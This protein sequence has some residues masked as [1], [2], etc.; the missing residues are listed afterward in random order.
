MAG[1]LALLV[2]GAATAGGTLN[3]SSAA[4]PNS[5]DPHIATGGT[6]SY[7]LYDLFMGLTSFDADGRVIPGAAE[8]WSV[9]ADGLAYT[10]T[11]RPGLQW[12]DG[13]TLTSEDFLYSAR[14]VVTPATA[15]RFAS[16]FYPVKNARH[17]LRGELPPDALG[18]EAPDARTLI[19]RLESPAPYFLQNLA[20]NV[21][22]PVPRKQIEALG[23]QWTRPGNMVSNGPF[24]LAEWVPNDRVTLVRNPRFFDAAGVSLE[25]VNWYPS[26]NQ[27]TSLKRYL[28]G[29]IDI[30][31]NFPAE[32]LT[33][34]RR[35]IP[36]EVRIWPGLLLGYVLLNNRRPPFDDQRVRLALAM[37]LDREG[38]V[39]KIVTPGSPPAYAM[40]PP[41]IGNYDHPKPAYAGQPMAERIAEAR[42]L[43]A[44]AG[45]GPERPL[46]F[47]LV[48]NTLEENRRLAVAM[49][50]MWQAVGV[51]ANLLNRDLIA[52]NKG[53]RTGDFD[54]LLYSWFAPNDDP[55][56]FLGLLETGNSSNYSG[57]GNPR[58]DAMLAAANALADPA[59]R[60][61]KLAEAEAMV[62][63]EQPVVPVFFYVRR[64]LVKPHV[65][66][67]T[68]NP[69]G[70]NLSRWLD[71]GK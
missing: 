49:A 5:L 44:A 39:A 47:D 6:A 68:E 28:A 4:E 34:L 42:R 24:M 19:Y 21:A 65:S 27:A 43:L 37:T 70:L 46:T 51:R 67:F 9:S 22:S 53:A 69:R 7:I 48:Y 40:T 62:L 25:R 63:A 30:L 3:R 35:D 12:S 57:Y 54:A 16:F 59:A 56:T 23:R 26:G 60:Y 17:I 13:S 20:S 2:A 71:V 52:L 45:Y 66:G 18:V 15:S 14:R 33:A 10:F 58:Y 41:A 36:A 29:E 11:L 61:A 38:I 1:F 31:L 64:F 55:Y 50:A 32:Q 8:S